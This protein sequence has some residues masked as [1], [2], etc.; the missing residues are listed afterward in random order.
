MDRARLQDR[1]GR[2]QATGRQGGMQDAGVPGAGTT[3]LGTEPAETAAADLPEESVA[4]APVSARRTA[5][6]RRRFTR[7][8]RAGISLTV[9]LTLVGL[10][11]IFAYLAMAYTGKSFRIP[12]WAV[13]EVEARLNE[14]LV[15]DRLPKGSA[16]SI[17]SVQFAVDDDFVPRFRL[18]DMRLI[19]A[20]GRSILALPE[21]H[22]TL[23]PT[24]LLSGKLRPSS[25]RLVGARLAV[26]RGADGRIDLQLDGTT[27]GPPPKS[28]AE[29][30]DAVGKLFSAPALANLHSIEV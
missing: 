12:T 2:T 28:L 25:L 26:R 4:P 6:R 18:E 24:A 8:K 5:L 27:S 21:A 22:L 23:D 19:K 15:A 16:V 30:L 3:G 29:V 13:A 11:L 14:G 17:G 9:V 20:D 7:P 10:T 1:A